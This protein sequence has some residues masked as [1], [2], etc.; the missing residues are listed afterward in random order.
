M[1]K[2]FALRGD[3]GS[4]TSFEIIKKNKDKP[5]EYWPSY[6]KYSMPDAEAKKIDKIKGNISQLQENLNDFPT[7][8]NDVLKIIETSFVKQQELLEK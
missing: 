1:E 4:D 3:A 6:S 8:I 7:E 2:S 5:L